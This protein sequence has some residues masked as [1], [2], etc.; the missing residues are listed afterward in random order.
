MALTVTIFDRVTRKKMCEM[1]YAE[2][3]VPG[4]TPENLKPAQ[5]K[6]L[7]QLAIDMA[8]ATAKSQIEL[9]V[10]SNGEFVAAFLDGKPIEL[11]GY[12]TKV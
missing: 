5:I 11:P 3:C 1:P 12:E 4:L 2:Y 6:Q 9:A 8:I 7:K 10:V